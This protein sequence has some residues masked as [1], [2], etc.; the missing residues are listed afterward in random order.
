MSLYNVDENKNM[1]LDAL[2]APYDMSPSTNLGSIQNI[3]LPSVGSY[4]DGYI[5]NDTKNDYVSL[6]FPTGDTNLYMLIRYGKSGTT[7]YMGL[8]SDWMLRRKNMSTILI[9]TPESTSHNYYEIVTFAYFS[10]CEMGGTPRVMIFDK[11]YY[12][13]IR[14]Q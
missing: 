8:G 4:I 11:V 5:Y 12:R 9:E 1:V 10:Y 13:I 6:K 3:I 14:L 7:T 2:F